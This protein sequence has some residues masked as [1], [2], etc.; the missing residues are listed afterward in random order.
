MPLTW[1]TVSPYCRDAGS[2][3]V[4]KVSVAD[5]TV[6]GGRKWRYQAH[7]RVAD[8][9]RAGEWSK[10]RS[11]RLGIF[12]TEASAIGVCETDARAIAQTG[13]SD[14]ENNHPRGGSPAE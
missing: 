8:E 10:T 4:E 2:H 13:E 9:R 14:A 12:G 11:V 3:V 1:Q 6:D 5:P 7:R